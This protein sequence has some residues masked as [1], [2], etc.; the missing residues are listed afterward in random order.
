MPCQVVSK[1]NDSSN[2]F[3]SGPNSILTLPKNRHRLSKTVPFSC[4][5]PHTASCRPRMIDWTLALGSKI[6]PPP[7]VFFF[8][9][10]GAARF[11]RCGTHRLCFCDTG[12]GTN[13]CVRLLYEMVSYPHSMHDSTR[14]CAPRAVVRRS[15][16]LSS[17]WL[18]KSS[19][20]AH[21]RKKCISWVWC[22]DRCTEFGSMTSLDACS[23]CCCNDVSK[24]ISLNLAVNGAASRSCKT[25]WLWKFGH[26]H[27]SQM[28]TAYTLALSRQFLSP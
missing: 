10:V 1:H 23:S 24:P 19:R 12:K 21:M 9:F 8:F 18:H 3:W 2:F 27:Q 17:L 4:L 13:R 5:L 26:F 15:P 7:A 16:P 14:C 11:L 20:Q 25:L 6:A 22:T 28:L